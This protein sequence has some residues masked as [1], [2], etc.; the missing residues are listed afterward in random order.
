MFTILGIDPGSTRSGVVRY[1]TPFKRVDSAA[2]MSNEAILEML[3]VSFGDE[4]RLVMEEFENYGKVTGRTTRDAIRWSGRFMEAWEGCMSKSRSG[5]TGLVT[6]R[7]VKVHLCGGMSYRHPD[8]GQPMK[9]GDREVRGAL[10]ERFEPSGGG[11]TPQIGI[12]SQPGPL[13]EVKTH[14]WAALAVAV[15]YAEQGGR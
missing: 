8:T 15:T 7:A 3:R 1:N 6:R 4:A 10:L 5:L 2:V 12:K 11:K 9:V 14:C 13:Y